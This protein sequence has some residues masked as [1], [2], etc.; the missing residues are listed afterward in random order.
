MLYLN[1]IYISYFIKYHYLIN[2][3][4]IISKILIGEYWVPKIYLKLNK[5]NFFVFLVYYG[6]NIKYVEWVH[7]ILFKINY[8]WYIYY[9]QLQQ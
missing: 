1:I 9:V 6:K 5:L 7:N 4:I 8:W 2:V 3:L